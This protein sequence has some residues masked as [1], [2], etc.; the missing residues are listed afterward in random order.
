MAQRRGVWPLV[1]VPETI[2]RD[3][4][5]TH[6]GAKVVLL[7]ELDCG[8]LGT[9][10]IASRTGRDESGRI[11]TVRRMPVA[12]LD[13]R[14]LGQLAAAAAATVRV[15]HPAIVKVLDVTRVGDELWSLSEQI[16]GVLLATLLS[17]FTL[18]A[19]PLSLGVALRIVTDLA[20]AAV[21]ARRQLFPYV[22][23]RVVWNQAC[24]VAA[25]GEALVMDIG[26]VDAF[27]S[28]SGSRANSELVAE[29]APEQ[30][31]DAVIGESADVFALGQIL[32]GLLSG[33]RRISERSL[34]RTRARLREGSLPPLGS[35]QHGSKVPVAIRALADRSAH[36]DP[37]VRPGSLLE[38]IDALESLPVGLVASEREVAE[39]VDDLAR[40]NKVE[41]RCGTSMAVGRATAR[42]GASTPGHMSG[43][44]SSGPTHSGTF[45]VVEVPTQ[46]ELAVDLAYS[47]V[48]SAGRTSRIPSVRESATALALSDMLR[49]PLK[50]ALETPAREAREP[51][52]TSMWSGGVS[53]APLFE[54]EPETE[55]RILVSQGVMLREQPA[56]GC[57][58]LTEAAG[59]P[60]LGAAEYATQTAAPSARPALG[61]LW[62]QVAIVAAVAAASVGTTLYWPDLCGAAASA[63]GKANAMVGRKAPRGTA[64]TRP[65]P[66][67]HVDVPKNTPVPPV[68][69]G[70][71]TVV[72]AADEPLDTSGKAESPRVAAPAPQDQTEPPPPDTVKRSSPSGLTPGTGA[73]QSASP[74][75]GVRRGSSFAAKRWG[76]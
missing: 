14:E 67:T 73:K 53:E 72:G 23:V 26:L 68:R 41:V 21:A 45:A 39:T 46:P 65:G 52:S 75:R 63:W 8:A 66:Q 64:K 10:W 59:R 48:A 15:A 4:V 18:R 69:R 5:S 43:F 7:N 51:V 29:L 71:P 44:H 74:K 47:Y 20:Q 27:A 25:Y 62:R 38:L 70:L 19:E 32:W 50:P 37:R 60:A 58:S 57:E 34:S 33:Q 61:P 6:D 40:R 12:G 36:S 11:I 9:R 2:Q 24:F 56:P 1:R 16:D 13:H 54:V 76:I 49:A 28:C 35:T 31:D 17:D 42:P 55:P 30:L 22:P 3:T